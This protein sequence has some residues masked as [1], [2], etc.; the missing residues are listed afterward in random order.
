MSI[1]DVAIKY[2][3][4]VTFCTVERGEDVF[5]ANGSLVFE[6]KDIVSI[7]ATPT[8]AKAF[9][10][11]IDYKL[12]PVKDA[13]ICGGGPITY[14]LC[15]LLRGS[16]IQ[17]TVVEKNAERCNELAND[18][19]KVTVINADP[20]DEDILK[21]EGISTADA[22][23][24]LTNLDEENILLSLFAKK[25]GARKTVTKINRIDFDNI[26]NHLDHDSMVYPKNIT[27][28]TIVSYVRAL[29]N[30]RGSN[31]ETVYNLIK[32]RVEAAEFTVSEDSPIIDP[33]LMELSLK[34]GVL[35]ATIQRG[36]THITPHGQDVIE[37]GD[38]VVIVTKDLPLSD[39]TD[40]L[41]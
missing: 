19:E 16:G 21:E 11:K 13:L 6:E 34:P 41:N 5:I 20:A 27:A 4:Q 28:D 10:K 2:R 36:K 15:E 22:F 18:F 33:P 24:S 39:I 25:S 38:S 7:I 17:C 1:K 3:T 23:V 30:R 40:I 26:T 37:S 12:Q 14:Y 35:I 29:G 8:R 9:F 32:G 31:I